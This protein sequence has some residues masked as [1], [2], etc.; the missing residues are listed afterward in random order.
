[1]FA[2]FLFNKNKNIFLNSTF[3]FP[4]QIIFYVFTTSHTIYSFTDWLHLYKHY[5]QLPSV[6]NC[7]VQHLGFG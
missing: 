5:E 6:L 2:N 1:M 3:I 4:T 7:E